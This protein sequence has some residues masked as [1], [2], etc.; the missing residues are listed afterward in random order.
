MYVRPAFG[1]RVRAPKPSEPIQVNLELGW[2]LVGES[3]NS[4]SITSGLLSHWAFRLV[5]REKEVSTLTSA[6]LIGES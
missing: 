6:I 4:V 2:A 5:T 3:N 1:I